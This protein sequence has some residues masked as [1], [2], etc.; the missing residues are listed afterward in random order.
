MVASGPEFDWYISL[1]VLA[2]SEQFLLI[3]KVVQ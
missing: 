3:R 1:L 2:L